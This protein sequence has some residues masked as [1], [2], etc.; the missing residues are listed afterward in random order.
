LRDYLGGF[1]FRGD[2]VTEACGT[3]SGGEKARLVL[4]LIAWQAPNLLLLDEPTNHLDVEMRF[5]LNRALQEYPGAVV[6]V[7]HDRHLL[8]STT[9]EYLLVDGGRTQRFSGDLDDYRRWLVESQENPPGG[10]GDERRDKGHSAAERKAQRRQ[11][12]EQRQQRQPLV[13]RIRQIEATMERQAT[14]RRTL[15]QALTDTGLYRDDRKEELKALLEQQAE[16]EKSYT[17]NES[18]WLELHESLEAL[19]DS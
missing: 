7:S 12:A 19:Q 17:A 6:L 4:A 2:R 3:F 13:K 11:A 1:D 16:L 18:E 5:A 9:D 14:S 8:R 10:N 15:E